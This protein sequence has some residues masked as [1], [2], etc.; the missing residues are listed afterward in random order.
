MK[1]QIKWGRGGGVKPKT[2]LGDTKGNELG[3]HLIVDPILNFGFDQLVE[4][5][6]LSSD[7]LQ[8]I[9]F[10]VVEIPFKKSWK[11]YDAS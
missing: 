6:P 10:I 7:S 2:Y 9:N 11:N 1:Q 4:L 3:G 8:I 5:I